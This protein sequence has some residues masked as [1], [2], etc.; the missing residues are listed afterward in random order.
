VS[1]TVL[2]GI[3]AAAT[4]HKWLR[5][6]YGENMPGAI[7]LDVV[8]QMLPTTPYGLGIRVLLLTQN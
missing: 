7:D 3:T 6:W 4:V 2:N 1:A 8:R 5:A